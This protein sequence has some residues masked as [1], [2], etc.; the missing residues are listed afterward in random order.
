MGRAC[1]PVWGDGGWYALL[2]PSGHGDCAR[3][4]V[5]CGEGADEGGKL[6]PAHQEVAGEGLAEALVELSLN[7]LNE[8]GWHV[9][10]HRRL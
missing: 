3:A 4:E 1:V 10:L 2:E 8:S 6:G 7:E 5:T 9:L